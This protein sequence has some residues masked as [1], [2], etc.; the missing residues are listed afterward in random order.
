MSVPS[1]S[2]NGHLYCINIIDDF[3]S[4]VWL[5]P[6]C[7]KADAGSTLRT[8]LTA[9]E[10]QTAHCLRSF[11]TDNGELASSQ[12][13]QFCSERGIL[14]LLTALYT[15]AYNG[16]IEHLHRTLMDKACAMQ[17]VCHAPFD[18]W[19]ELCGTAAHLTN[20]TRTSSNNGHTPYE[21]WHGCKPSLSHLREIS[22]QAFAL[23]P[24]H[25]SKLF[26]RSFP[27]TLIGYA[28]NSKA[29]RLWDRSTNKVFNS[30]HVSFIESHESTALPPSL[31]HPVFPPGP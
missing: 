27:C 10:V 7:S 24:T 11:V 28:L 9:I 17:S 30:F 12:I 19:D 16:R 3:L 6:L 22:C 5:L 2:A 13:H 18:L 1:H 8:W 4:F 15:S 25:N 21:L 29:Y 26:P 14:H 23:I 31:P 20:L